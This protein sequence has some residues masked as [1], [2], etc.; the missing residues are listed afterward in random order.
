MTDH[1]AF[2]WSEFGSA[3][4]EVTGQVVDS[5]YRPDVILGIARGGLIPAGAIAYALDCK[6]LFTIN[7]EFYTGVDERLDLP[8]M[9]PPILDVTDLDDLS[10]L[11]VDDIADTGKTMELV[12]NFCIDHVAEARSAVLYRKPGSVIDPDY[13][14]RLT[15]NWID[16]P[17]SVEPVITGDR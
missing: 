9:L 11:I 4:R 1:E 14:W 16:F 10:V 8:V 2:S 5:G 3:A 15:E 12:Q 7:V 6:N 13:S 17:W